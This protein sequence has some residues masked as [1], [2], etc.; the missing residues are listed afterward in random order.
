MVA[1]L[2]NTVNCSDQHPTLIFARLSGYL[3]LALTDT[4]HMPTFNHCE[5]LNG[6]KV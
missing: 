5:R 1:E 3:N 2:A 4:K 6:F